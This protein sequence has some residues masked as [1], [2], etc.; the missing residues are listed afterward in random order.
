M[1]RLKKN[2]EEKEKASEDV[3]LIENE[4]ILSNT[5]D[6][7][8]TTDDKIISTDDNNNRTEDGI[9]IIGIGGKPTNK[10]QENTVQKLAPWEMIMQKE[11]DEFD[12][13]GELAIVSFPNPNDL[14]YLNVL[15]SPNI[16][17]WVGA[18]YNFCIRIPFEYPYKDPIVKCLTKIYHPNITLTGEVCLSILKLGWKC[19][20]SINTVIIN[21]QTIFEFPYPD[22]PL[23]KGAA[24]LL[25]TDE[26]K[27]ATVIKHILSGNS[28][29]GESFPKLI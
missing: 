13:F 27:F 20:Y 17:Y 10:K 21:L 8:I 23:N 16:G 25:R 3:E 2:K 7:M 29:D 24:A 5:N 26:S 22:D 1:L 18:K 4:V 12:D 14:S 15:I 19:T 6:K 28:Y 9:K 11:M